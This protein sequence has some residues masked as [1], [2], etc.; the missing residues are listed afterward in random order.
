MKCSFLPCDRDLTAE[1][2]EVLWMGFSSVLE[3]G[4]AATQKRL[5]R[6]LC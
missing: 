4:W 6:L 5:S 1:D 2:M 3:G